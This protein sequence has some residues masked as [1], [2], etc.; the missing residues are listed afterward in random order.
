MSSSYS[1]SERRAAGGQRIGSAARRMPPAGGERAARFL[2]PPD[3]GRLRRNQRRIQ[4]QRI[5]VI[6]FNVLVVAAVILGSMWLWRRTQSDARFAVRTIEIAGAVHTPRAALNAVT[7]QYAGMN[8]FR[9]DIDRV[10]RDLGGLAWIRRIDIEKKL[11]DTLRITVV[12]RTPVALLR[13][14]DAL[15]YVDQRGVELADLSPAVGDSDL[16]I[17]VDARGGEL[18]RSVD[19]ITSLRAHDIAVYSRI[20]EVRPIAPNGFAV[21]DRELGAVVY[22]NADDISAKWRRF[23]AVVRAEQLGRSAM[24]YADLRFND[25]IVIKLIKPITNAA[26]VPPQTNEHA[27]ITN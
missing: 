2:R 22:A 8:L 18:A 10:Q 16:P 21:F 1:T 27:E 12:E 9:I 20:S 17:I 26:P 23:Y 7:R 24:E 25:R 13:S 3:V 15:R 5:F 11:P 6:V 4:A 14:G 19:F